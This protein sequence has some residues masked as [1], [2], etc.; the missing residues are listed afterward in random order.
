KSEKEIAPVD[1]LTAVNV[2]LPNVGQTAR[3]VAEGNKVAGFDCLTRGRNDGRLAVGFERE[4]HLALGVLTFGG[5]ALDP[6][7]LIW[8]VSQNLAGDFTFL[9]LAADDDL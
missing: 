3:D 6:D 1:R 9:R 8:L 5:N 2:P 4:L 7:G